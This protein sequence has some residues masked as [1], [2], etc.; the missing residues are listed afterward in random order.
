VCRQNTIRCYLSALEFVQIASRTERQTRQS[1]ACRYNGQHRSSRWSVLRNSS[2]YHDDRAKAA[3]KKGRSDTGTDQDDHPYIISVHA[4][5][6]QA[7]G[8]NY[9]EAETWR[10][11]TTCERPMNRW[12]TTTT[13]TNNYNNSIQQSTSWEADSLSPSHEIPSIL[14]NRRVYDRVYK[15]P[16]LVRIFSQISPVTSWRSILIRVLSSYLR[17]SLPSCQLRASPPKTYIHLSSSWWRQKSSN[18][19]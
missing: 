13:T 15:S 10:E 4:H 2:Q 6:K 9:I 17:L 11:E 18:S 1:R 16:P 12:I 8:K 19:W 5:C 3:Q 7:P 14:R